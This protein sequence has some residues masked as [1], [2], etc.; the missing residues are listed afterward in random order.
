MIH[1][2]IEGENACVK[3]DPSCETRPGEMI[4][5]YPD[6]TKIKLFDAQTG[7]NLLYMNLKNE[8]R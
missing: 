1:G 7:D 2:E 5:L 6:M 4:S 8:K 3:L